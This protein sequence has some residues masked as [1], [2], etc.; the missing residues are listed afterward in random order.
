MMHGH[1]H[2]SSTVL[3]FIQYIRMLQRQGIRSGPGQP[4]NMPACK[5]HLI[6]SRGGG[7]GHTGA[8]ALC[9]FS[10]TRSGGTD[11]SGRTGHGKGRDHKEGAGAR[12]PLVR[13]RLSSPPSPASSRRHRAVSRST[14]RAPV[15]LMI[16]D[17]CSRGASSDGRHR[18]YRTQVRGGV[19][20]ASHRNLIRSRGP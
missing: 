11:K 2:A 10:R 13:K 4:P 12:A 16:S 9:C 7:H 8:G 3:Q 1:T 18:K 15:S 20:L 6:S 5:V 14:T 19:V 17:K